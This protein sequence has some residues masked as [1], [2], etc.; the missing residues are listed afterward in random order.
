MYSGAAALALA[1]TFTA[2]L[3]GTNVVTGISNTSGLAN[4][5]TIVGA[6]IPTGTTITNIVASTNTTPGTITL[7]ASAT[8]SGTGTLSAEPFT[9][10]QLTAAQVQAY[11]NTLYQGYVAFFNQNVGSNWMTLPEFTKFNPS[12]LYVATATQVAALTTAGWTPA[13]LENAIRQEALDPSGVAP[14]GTSA[15]NVSGMNV[16]ITA[17]DN[18]G[19]TASQTFITWQQL[20]S[21]NYSATVANATA[22]GEVIALSTGLEFTTGQLFVSA[23]NTLNL[24]ATTGSITV[25]GTS[26]NLTVGPVTA[27][28]AI[29]IAAPANLLGATPSTEIKSGGAMTL[30]AATG[31]VGSGS[32]PLVVKPNGGITTFTPEGQAYLSVIAI[33]TSVVVTSTKSTSTYGQSVTFTA[34]VSDTAGEVPAGVINFYYGPSFLGTGSALSGSGQSASSTITTSTLPTSVNWSIRAVFTPSDD[35]QGASGS[36]TLTVNPAPLTI[37]VTSPSASKTYGAT[38]TLSSTAFTTSGLL[39]SDSVTSVTESS[40]GAAASAAVGIYLIIA[41]GVQGSGVY[42]YAITYVTG[43]LTVSKAQTKTTVTSP[44]TVGQGQQVFFTATVSNTSGTS[45]TPTGSVQF[46]VNGTN[47]GAPVTLNTLGIAS[48]PS[49]TLQTL[50]TYTIT[51]VFSSATSNFVSS[52]TSTGSTVQVVT[53]Q[54]LVVTNANDSGPGSLRAAIATAD[55]SSGDTITFAPALAGQTI[56]LTTVGDSTDDGS[57][58]LEITTAMTIDASAAPGLTIAGPGTTGSSAFRIFL[59]NAPLGDTLSLKSATITGGDAAG[60][61]GGLFDSDGTTVLTNV[62][63]S[64]NSASGDGGGLASYGGTTTLIDCTVTGNSAFGGGG[65]ATY[66]QGTT[67]LTGSSVSGNSASYAGG[68]VLNDGST[69]LSGC[70]ISGNTATNGGGIDNSGTLMMTACTVSGNTAKGGETYGGYGGYGGGLG[71]GIDNASGTIMLYSSTISNNSAVDGG[72]IYSFAEPPYGTATSTLTNCTV[73]GNSAHSSGGGISIRDASILTLYGGALSGNSAGRF[74]GGLLDDGTDAQAN[75]YNTT[76]SNNSAGEGGGIATYCLSYF[77]F[78]AATTTLTDCTVSGNKASGLGGGLAT[79]HEGITTLYGSTVS[80]N[81]AGTSGGGLSNQGT[82]TLYNSTVSGN[83]AGNNGG[84]L[85]NSPYS[86][87]IGNFHYSTPGQTNLTNVTVSGN[88]AGNAG[89]IDDAAGTVT[90]GNT[91]VAGNSATTVSR[92]V[93]GNF[94][95]QGNNL[96]GVTGNSSGWGSDLTGSGASPLAA[97]LGVLGYYG[98]PT[99]TMPLLPG[100]PAINAGDNGLLS[101]GDTTDQR[102][103]GFPRILNSTVDIGAYETPNGTKSQTVSFAAPAAQTFD[104]APITLTATASSG[105]GTLF[106]VKSGPATVAGNVLTITGAGTV[107]IEASQPGNA[108]YAP[109]APVDERLNVAAAATT[110][111][112]VSSLNPAGPAQAVFFTATVQVTGTTKL[113]TDGSVQFSVDGTNLGAP[114][115]V[116]DGI[117]SSSDILLAPGSHTVNAVYSSATGNFGSSFGTLSSGELVSAVTT[118]NLSAAIA[119][120]STPALVASTNT[121]LQSIS[122]A[123]NALSAQTTPV[124]ITVNLGSGSFNDSTFKPPAGVTV[125]VT[126]NGTSTTFVG[127]S[128]AFVVTQGTVIISDATF[129][130]DSDSPTI[131]VTGGTLI[132]RNDLIESSTGFSEPAIS[133]SGSG[134]VDLGTATDPGGNTLDVNGQGQFIENTTGNSVPEFGDTFELN[135]VAGS[136]PSSTNLSTSAVFPLA[137]QNVTLTA[138]VQ[139]N[140]AGLVMPTG[141]VDFFD[142]TTNTDL[143]PGGV[144]FASG[145]STASFAFPT[146]D[147]AGGNNVITATYSGDS[148]FSG[149]QD[150]LTEILPIY[151]NSADTGTPDGI[152]PATGYLTIQAAINAAVAGETILVESGVYNESDVISVPNLTIEADTG[153]TPILDGTGLSAPGFDVTATGVTIS[154]LTIQNFSGSSAVDVVSGASLSLAGDL[155]E[156]NQNA[157]GDGGGI[158]DAGTLNVTGSTIEDNTAA[159]GG[160]IFIAGGVVEV[161]GGTVTGN[162]AIGAVGA[163]GPAGHSGGAGATAMGGGIFESGGKLQLND[164]SINSNRAVGGQGGQGGS[165]T[166]TGGGTGAGAA[167]GAGGAGLGGGLYIAGGTVTVSGGLFAGNSAAGGAGGQGGN[168]VLGAAGTNGASGSAGLGYGGGIDFP[169]GGLTITNSTV[170]DNSAGSGG[171]I[172]V[173]SWNDGAATLTAVN[174]TIAYNTATRSGGG[175][176]VINGT[177]NLYNTIVATNTDASGADDIAGTGITSNSSNNLVGVDET[178]T[179]IGSINPILFGPGNPGLDTGLGINGGPTQTIAL[180]P[181]SSALGAGSSTITGVDVPTVD[182]RGFT[183]PEYATGVVDIGAFEL[184]PAATQPPTTIYVNSADSGTADGLTPATGYTT[185]QGAINAAAAG[186]TILVE[187]GFGYNESDLVSVPGLTIEADASQGATPVLVGT[188]QSGPGFEV[189]AAGVT[190]SGLTIQDFTGSSAIVVQFGASLKLD[191]DVITENSAASGGGIASA[192]KLTLID[193]VISEND[194]TGAGGGI[195]DSGGTVAVSGGSIEGNTAASGGG[196]IY[197]AG[198]TLTVTGVTISKNTAGSGGGGIDNDGGDVT[199]SGGAILS[200]VAGASGGGIYGHSGAVHVAGALIQSNAAASGGGIYQAGGS[201]IITDSTLSHNTATVDGGGIDDSGGDITISGGAI[202]ANA[203]SGSGGGIYDHSGAVQVAGCMIEFNSAASGGG[204]YQAAGSLIIADSTLSSNTASIDG[205]GLYDGA[206]TVHVTGGAIQLNSA[207]SGG[208]IYQAGGSL[209]ITDNVL[210]QN[211][212]TFDGGGIYDGDGAVTF[213][214]GTISN[215]AAGTDGGGLYDSAGKAEVS[216]PP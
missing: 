97:H 103:T 64:G 3:N 35:F 146:S 189:T 9:P 78:P 196:A 116:V 73:T 21:G 90:I 155:I 214:G 12:F 11:A 133:I 202:S 207:A 176:D 71:G 198:G 28:G 141:T 60:D 167:G 137:G 168:G 1:E 201:L 75:L 171:G 24:T 65:L 121:T 85:F 187:T 174:D 148:T 25:Q 53:P 45:A 2:T 205:G 126:G 149:S 43:S 110:T 6:G 63:I 46:K 80:A 172:A 178:G 84:G 17:G 173:P 61:G 203:A 140:Y 185:I 212:A 20:Q 180:L 77:F 47:L 204:I 76:V 33:P 216:A 117:A 158:Y 134:S 119:T 101:S 107:V 183:R 188:G 157:G 7:S 42:N 156:H 122:S 102:G 210:S 186:D 131:V 30:T 127:H 197:V 96:I 72:G 69:T 111:T 15:A 192:G 115:V 57:S 83:S 5:Q 152:T 54:G 195:Y 125:I 19:Q 40:T 87:S 32:S 50:G 10:A 105:L 55:M 161:F 98:G 95:S 154:G 169:R 164:V 4:G 86:I 23:Q 79:L 41:T 123:V 99:E 66:S 182:E 199:I 89:G 93:A 200:N 135:G 209:V 208:G 112:L 215:N 190:I 16:T 147:L 213:A 191:D 206:G 14:L 211:I 34:T 138:T 159:S 8:A 18:I 142:T 162:F 100:S 38:E 179:V 128:P 181:G 59:V 145:T 170:A 124:S 48:S 56:H 175:L 44:P 94:N 150:S 106:A 143:T 120:T 27:G 166:T 74:G 51:A 177:A 37:R 88:T 139:T 108:T 26:P 22:P 91:I 132:L 36:C 130:T 62:A 70:T 129:T 13:M 29:N 39:G 31:N 81:S 67:T 58:A 52:S 193:S 113:A 92:D 68:G 163:T 160:G 136:I 114:A 82:T 49:T 104:A 153:Q 165:G 109:A 144:S 184:Q 151:V 118:A 194:A